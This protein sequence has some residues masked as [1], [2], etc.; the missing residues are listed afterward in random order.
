MLIFNSIKPK[1]RAAR[2]SIVLVD[3]LDGL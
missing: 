3:Y 2:L 1:D